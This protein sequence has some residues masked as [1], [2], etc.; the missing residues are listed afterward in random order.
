M[1]DLRALIALTSAKVCQFL[2]KTVTRGG[3]TAL[4]GWVALTIDANLLT[5]VSKKIK[6]GS[7]I[8][9]GTNGK[10]TTT[11]T[12]SSILKGAGFAVISNQAGSNLE[13]GLIS[14]ASEHFKSLQR[15]KI[16]IAVWEVD[17][18]FF[19]KIAP[20]I[21]PKVVVITNL[22]RDQLDRYGEIDS[23]AHKWKTAL[24]NLSDQ[25]WIVVNADDINVAS[26]VV[27]SR[28]RTHFYGWS[29]GSQR[30]KALPHAAETH[31]CP[32]CG[33]LLE[34]EDIFLSH[35]GTYYCPLCKYKSPELNTKI[36]SVK[37]MK[38]QKQL[39]N[40]VT[41]FTLKSADRCLNFTSVLPGEYNL[42]NLAAAFSAATI[43]SID[44]KIITT[45]ISALKPPFGRGEII[46][47]RGRVLKFLLT[48][49]PAGFNEAINVLHE[50]KGKKKLL[51]AL[52][53]EIADGRDISWIWDVDMEKLANQTSVVV[54]S[55]IRSEDLALRLKYA[56]FYRESL[57]IE[58]DLSKAFKTLVALTKEGEMA[59]IIPTYTAMLQLRKALANWGVAP[60]IWQDR[61]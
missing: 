57:V 32:R 45:A 61:V 52:N 6:H 11:R 43:L 31:L 56:N 4:P 2:L 33:A 60:P 29:R 27:G 19:P 25:T 55:G 35:Y 39:G 10:T 53:D 22:F 14:T 36:V 59:Y 3:G 47:F 16:D 49:N 34:I 41:Q 48:K 8:V 1:D 26:L 46:Q 13:R 42:Y 38:V 21:N 54:I 24:E 12:L 50:T 5:K 58:K 18:G 37:K 17:E 30:K 28:P 20:K 23:V 7:I 51:L 15:G 40:M 44:P 9:T